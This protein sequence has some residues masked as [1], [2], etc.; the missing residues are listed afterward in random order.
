MPSLKEYLF[1]EK[2]K[3]FPFI[4]EIWLF[5]S[6]AR[7]DHL[8]RSDIDLA[9]NLTE[10]KANFKRNIGDVIATAD[11]LLKIDVTYLNDELD[12][13]FITLINNDKKL[14]YKMPQI[15][16]QEIL[17]DLDAAVKKLVE[18]TQLEKNDVVRDATIQR[19]EFTF[20]LFWKA[21]K[22]ILSYEGDPSTSPRNTFEKSYQ[23]GLI[24]NEKAFLNM[25]D[26]RN[27]TSHVYNQEM[28]EQIYKNILKHVDTLQDHT[29][30]LIK[31]YSQV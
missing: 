4:K 21:C 18:V 26:D 8:E 28:S 19:F 9:I 23:Y 30:L 12:P 22:K 13:E 1:I 2:L 6:R 5:G 11:T 14:I 25:L 15:Y 29:D 20:E 17:N 10:N 7:A 16:I 31:K 3:A 24:D 27:K